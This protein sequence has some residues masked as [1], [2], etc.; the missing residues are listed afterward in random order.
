MPVAPHPPAHAL[1]PETGVL[2]VL[3]AG[4]RG[5]RL[6][7]LTQT[8]C[9]P[10]VA[11]GAGRIVDYVLSNAVEAGLTR[12]LVATQY[13]PLELMLHL[14][15]DWAPRF[16]ELALRDGPDVTG[17]ED[18]YLGTADAVLANLAEIDAKAPR[19]VLILSA[20]HVYRMDFAAMITAHRDSGAAATVA[21]TPVERAE[22]RHFGIAHVDA[23]GRVAG[24]VEKPAIPPAMPG[25]PDRA[26]ASMGIYVFDWGWLRGALIR[27]ARQTPG[28]V[29]FGH[30]ILPLAL[31]EG[32]LAA[33]ALPDQAD[34]LPAYWRDVGTLDAYRRAQLDLRRGL[35]PRGLMTPPAAP[36]SRALQASSDSVILPGANVPPDCRLSRCIIGPGATLPAGLVA[37]EDPEEDMRWFRVTAQ[38]TTLIT[39]GMLARRATLLRPR[40]RQHLDETVSTTDVA[41]WFSDRITR[42][43]EA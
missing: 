3:L 11:F 19:Q 20:D 31:A 4:G 32:E 39:Q 5:S 12:M 15:R 40:R 18:G 24:F 7:E 26:L 13:Q 38:G 8:T 21:V 28:G 27:A 29:D 6:H 43:M 1:P 33:H 22:A 17:T 41:G 30:H 37:G 23:A 25:H 14:S 34:G 9:K 35:V 42:R 10:A 36:W 2:A 16:A